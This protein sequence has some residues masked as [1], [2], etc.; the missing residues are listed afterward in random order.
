RR[1]VVLGA[2][3]ESM[4]SVFDFAARN[5]KKVRGHTLYYYQNLPK[6]IVA[7]CE[8]KTNSTA[9]IEKTIGEWITYRVARYRDRISYWIINEM[10][11]DDGKLRIDPVTKRLGDRIF[12]VLYNAA[13]DADPNVVV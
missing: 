4:K 6:P 11:T 5:H 7:L 2:H 13:R 12:D 8:D 9:V 3:S 10:I 1:T